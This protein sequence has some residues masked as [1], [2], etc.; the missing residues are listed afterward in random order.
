[1]GAIRGAEVARGGRLLVLLMPLGVVIT[2]LVA[3]SVTVA[4]LM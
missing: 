1:M 3:G 4:A 2:L